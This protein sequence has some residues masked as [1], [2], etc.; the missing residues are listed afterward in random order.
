M[1][2]AYTSKWM[3][4][5]PFERHMRCRLTIKHRILGQH[6]DGLSDPYVIGRRAC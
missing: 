2:I 3:A 4:P 5:A 1:C 6:L